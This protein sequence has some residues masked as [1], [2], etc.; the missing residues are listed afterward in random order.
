LILSND[1][2][3]LRKKTFRSSAKA[4]RDLRT[5]TEN[6]LLIKAGDK[7]TTVYQFK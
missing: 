3:V 6:G 2:I 1:T 7:R 5:A 4:S